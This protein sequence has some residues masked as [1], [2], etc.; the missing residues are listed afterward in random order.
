MERKLINQKYLVGEMIGSGGSSKVHKVYKIDEDFDELATEQ[1]NLENKYEEFAIKI[2]TSP[3]YS[4]SKEVTI[5]HSIQSNFKDF[6][7][8]ECI[9][10][11]QTIIDGE[12]ND[13]MI[14]KL[15][16]GGNLLNYI[17]TVTMTEYSLKLVFRQILKALIAIHNS[18][19]AHMDIKMGNILFDEQQ[20]KFWDFG[21]SIRTNVDQTL[22][23]KNYWYQGTRRYTA[24][25]ILNKETFSS[26]KADVFSLG[27]VLFIAATNL[28]PFHE[29]SINDTKF[30]R[31]IG[32]NSIKFWRRNKKIVKKYSEDLGD[33]IV[34]MLNPD[35]KQRLSLNEI[36][37]HSWF[38]K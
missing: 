9:E 34:S 7:I 37:N 8:V 12:S 19:Y 28:Y 16:Q 26:F 22:D 20:P 2:A 31:L 11:D 4:F 3:D 35:P 32:E 27:V 30:K 21:C 10:Y 5:A 6:S 13:F 25:E 38:S 14:M 23:G 1:L 36:V 18:G 29:A 17:K 15:V 24:P 33:L